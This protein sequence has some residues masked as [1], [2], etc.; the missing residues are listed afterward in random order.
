ML[1]GGFEQWLHALSSA[2]VGAAFELTVAIFIGS[3]FVITTVHR[4][5]HQV[6]TLTSLHF[7][8]DRATGALC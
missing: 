5:G 1:A 7:V 4:D 8:L 3:T 2:S 6:G